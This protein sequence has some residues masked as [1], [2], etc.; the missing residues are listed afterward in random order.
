MTTVN[1]FRTLLELQAFQNFSNSTPSQSFNTSS[2][3]Q[4]VLASVLQNSLNSASEEDQ[5]SSLYRSLSTPLPMNFNYTQVN[6]TPMNAVK[7]ITA[8]KDIEAIIQKASE[9]FNLP[10]KLIQSV[11]HQESGFNKNAVSRSGAA[12]LMQLMP[13][14]AK[15]LGV[16][17]V[18]DAEQNVLAGSKYL[19]SM[20]DRYNGNVSLALA[21]YN[22]GPGNVDKY[23]GIPPFK[24]TQNYVKKVTDHFYS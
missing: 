12:G 4:E 14:T 5:S 24:E 17:D 22:A 10:T 20:L 18:F 15:S 2:L 1:Q 9:Q 19:K 13:S 8:P 3:F 21:A 16:T 23:D 7:Q 11:I 6:S